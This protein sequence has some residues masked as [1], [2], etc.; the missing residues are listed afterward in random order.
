[1]LDTIFTSAKMYN[2][3]HIP[4]AA[5]A[6]AYFLMLSLFPI[7]VCLYEMLGS[8]F[9]STESLAAFLEPLLPDNAVDTILDFIV[10]VSEN[11]S[12]TMLMM[13]LAAMATTSAGAFRVIDNVTGEMRGEKRFTGLGAL[14][15]SFVFSIVF[16]IS[17]YFAAILMLTGNW[18]MSFLDEH[19]SFIHVS[20]SWQWGRFVLLFLLILV[21]TTGLYKITQP[22]HRSCLVL[23]GAAAASV[24]L[25]AVSVLFSYFISASVKYPLVYGSLASVMILM[26]WFY[27]CGNIIIGANILN[28]VLEKKR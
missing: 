5:A 18:L 24:L 21:I 10:Y 4:R 22:R 6:L 15:F 12:R 19:I 2:D 8:M 17:L 7:L 27:I 13:S 9:P 3:N 28:I 14:L 11:H 25:V 20:D 1:M 26:F 16:L 23:P